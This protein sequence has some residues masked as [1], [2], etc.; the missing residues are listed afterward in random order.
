MAILTGMPQFDKIGNIYVI[1][2]RSMGPMK[3]WMRSF[4]RRLMKEEKA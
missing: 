4:L 2:H 1:T 3:L